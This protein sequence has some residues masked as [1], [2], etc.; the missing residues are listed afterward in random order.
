MPRT[1]RNGE[2]YILDHAG[3]GK[4]PQWKNSVVLTYFD[5]A[6]IS[7]KAYDEDATENEYIGAGKIEV[8]GL[9]FP[10]GQIEVPILTDSGE[11]VGTVSG[12]YTIRNLNPTPLLLIK[13]VRCNFVKQHSFLIKSKPFF[14]AASEEGQVTTDHK[15]E[16]EGLVVSWTEGLR[17]RVKEGSKIT[18][19][20]LDKNDNGASIFKYEC[21]AKEF[22][23]QS[24][25][26]CFNVFGAD[27]LYLGTLELDFETVNLVSK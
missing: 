3:A 9:R 20:L 23:L 14:Q 16:T 19:S 1:H 26:R 4:E 25:T 6:L 11:S 5:E 8:K 24:G 18:L 22:R 12:K 2:W 15:E 27:F 7:V 21:N 10:G 13:N 17:L